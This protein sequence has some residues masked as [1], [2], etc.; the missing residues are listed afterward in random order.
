MSK[1]VK[2]TVPGA[3]GVRRS[4]RVYT[5]AIV[6]RLDWDAERK[7]SL[8]RAED[9]A[10]DRF[11]FLTEVSKLVVGAARYPNE[12]TG[13]LLVDVKV[14]QHEVDEARAWLAKNPTLGAAIINA[15][16][17]QEQ[18]N[19]EALKKAGGPDTVHVLAWSQS[20]HN[21]AKAAQKYIGSQWYN[22]VDVR[23]V[24]TVRH[25]KAGE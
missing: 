6:A 20:A 21:A 5:H 13:S 25:V 23:V 3:N 7:A 19:A 11:N 22:Y 2:H 18:R 14:K 9:R 15:V 17:E 8:A 24:E 16:L 12:R 10:R 4:P 1:S